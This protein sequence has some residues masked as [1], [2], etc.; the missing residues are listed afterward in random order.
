[1]TA[2]TISISQSTSSIS[3]EPTPSFRALSTRFFCRHAAKLNTKLAAA[4]RTAASSFNN[5]WTNS[6]IICSLC[7]AAPSAESKRRVRPALADAFESSRSNVNIKFRGFVFASFKACIAFF[8][9]ADIGSGLASLALR[10][11]HQVPTAGSK[12][13]NRHISTSGKSSDTFMC[14]MRVALIDDHVSR[15]STVAEGKD[16]PPSLAGLNLPLRY[17]TTDLVSVCLIRALGK[18]EEEA[19]MKER[20][21]VTT[22][23]NA[24]TWVKRM[25]SRERASMAGRD[26]EV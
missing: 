5:V 15:S 19:S 9:K 20:N 17:G 1:M 14:S 2:L 24:G 18:G 10:D 23:S 7:E 16:P 4:V 3:F 8:E 21:F 12:N 26:K 13:A 11:A 22:L 6:S 25:G